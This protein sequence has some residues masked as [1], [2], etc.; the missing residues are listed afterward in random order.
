MLSPS[1][2]YKRKYEGRRFLRN[3]TAHLQNY[4]ASPSRRID[5]EKPEDGGS[6]FFGKVGSPLRLYKKFT[7]E[8]GSL[9]QSRFE[10]LKYLPQS[11]VIHGLK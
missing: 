10:N 2:P 9:I 7:P 5:L 11:S 4:T 1:S 8:R 3:F 6:N